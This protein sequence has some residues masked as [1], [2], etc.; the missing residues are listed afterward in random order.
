MCP[1]RLEEIDGNNAHSCALVGENKPNDKDSQGAELL[2]IELS[3]SAAG[4]YETHGL[5]SQFGIE[6]LS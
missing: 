6:T 3:P 4:V 2:G 1:I 5:V